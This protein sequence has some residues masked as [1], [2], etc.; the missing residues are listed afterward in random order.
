MLHQTKTQ[1]EERAFRLR[2]IAMCFSPTKD[3]DTRRFLIELANWF[4]P[5]TPPYRPPGGENGVSEVPHGTGREVI[6]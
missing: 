5:G 1:S 3:K 4:D 6:V 2:N